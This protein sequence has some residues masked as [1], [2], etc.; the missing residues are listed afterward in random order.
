MMEV[1]FV[2][3]VAPIVRDPDAA[4]ALASLDRPSASLQVQRTPGGHEALRVVAAGGGGQPVLRYVGLADDV[5]VPQASIEFEVPDVS[6][7]R[8]SSP[9]RVID[10]FMRLAR[11]PGVRSPHGC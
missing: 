11:S 5:P 9:Q 3:S 4:Q 10:S 6:G 1:Q 8:R 7:Q 2:A